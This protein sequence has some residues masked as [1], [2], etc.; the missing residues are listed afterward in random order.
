M[1]YY[2]NKRVLWVL[3]TVLV[4]GSTFILSYSSFAQDQ[5]TESNQPI[6]DTWTTTKVKA[7]LVAA[8]GVKATDVSVTTVNG[9]VTL[10][11]NV[12]TSAQVEKAIAVAKSVKGV[13]SVD[14]SA[15][16]VHD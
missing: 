2:P 9:V 8:K 10:S 13:K 6:D 14:S 1:I 7:E 11:G 15:L 12:D 3:S 16:K 4:L 5:T